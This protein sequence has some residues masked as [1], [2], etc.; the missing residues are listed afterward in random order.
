MR[1]LPRINNAYS[2][3]EDQ[4]FSQSERLGHF[5]HAIGGRR[6]KAENNELKRLSDELS[7]MGFASDLKDPYYAM[8]VR[9]MA[10]HTKLTHI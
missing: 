6:S 1:P 8:F 10:Q 3:V 9:K 5:V 7:D 4:G 2:T